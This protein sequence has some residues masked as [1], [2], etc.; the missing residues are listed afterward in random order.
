MLLLLGDTA[1]GVVAAA[2]SAVDANV[3]DVAMEEDVVVDD[4]NDCNR[5]GTFS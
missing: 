3:A 2:E 5:I 1:L 4:G